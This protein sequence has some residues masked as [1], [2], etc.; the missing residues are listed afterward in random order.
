VAS[1]M[2]VAEVSLD[3]SHIWSGITFVSR[4]LGVGGLGW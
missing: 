1:S 3:L 2:P 4:E